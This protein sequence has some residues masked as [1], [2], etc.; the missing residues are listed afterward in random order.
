MLLTYPRR[1]WKENGMAQQVRDLIA[2]KPVTLSAGS[3][4]VDA[5]LAMRDFDVGAVIVL[6]DD[7][8]RGI[9]TDRDI[10]VRAI[11]NGSYPATTPIG[12]VCSRD[13]PAI[14]P[15]A[16]VDEAL[17]VMRD[18]ATRYVAVVENGQLVGVISIGEL[19]SRQLLVDSSLPSTSDAPP[20]R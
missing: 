9:A 1:V 7:Q 15:S 12:E 4:L 16:S 19:A 10:V 18:K 14:G 13:L 3:T 17:R 11:A 8:I 6:E 2:Q 20:H 5:A